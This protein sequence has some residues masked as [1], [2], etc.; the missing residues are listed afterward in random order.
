MLYGGAFNKKLK[1]YSRYFLPPQENHP[2]A[3]LKILAWTD[4][5]PKPR[6]S[7]MHQ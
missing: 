5:G 7:H 2:R 6:V 3:D 4:R 1:N